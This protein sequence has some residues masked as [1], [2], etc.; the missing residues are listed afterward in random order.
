MQYD[1]SFMI[2]VFCRIIGKKINKTSIA[3]F[4]NKISLLC[5]IAQ[6]LRLNLLCPKLCLHK[7]A[8]PY[9]EGVGLLILKCSLKIKKK[10]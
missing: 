1:N 3:N 5:H 8:C 10:R 9:K 7:F 2:Y 4:G 6:A